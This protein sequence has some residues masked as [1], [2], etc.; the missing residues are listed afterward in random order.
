ME[1]RESYESR[2]TTQL[3]LVCLPAAAGISAL[4]SGSVLIL[5]CLSADRKLVI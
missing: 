2:A 3:S 5:A 4:D 1:I